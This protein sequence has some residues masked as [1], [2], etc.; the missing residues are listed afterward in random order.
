MSSDAYNSPNYQAQL[1]YQQQVQQQLIHQNHQQHYQPNA[2]YI[3]QNL[4]SNPDIN[5][6]QQ[7]QHQSHFHQQQHQHIQHQHQQQ[8][9]QQLQHQQLQ[10][11]NLNST[12]QHQPKTQPPNV[13][14]SLLALADNF[15]KAQQYRLTIHCLESILLTLKGQDMPVVTNFHIQLKT[16]LNLCRLYLKHTVNSNQYINAHIEK[17]V[18]V[19]SISYSNY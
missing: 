11:T 5:H 18:N 1:K 19:Y 17:S 9:P 16:R 6:I 10:Q 8:Q 12:P 15:Q 3:N 14:L 13:Y 2:Q 4:T 7:H